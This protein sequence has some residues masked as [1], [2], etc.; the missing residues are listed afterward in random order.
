M[1]IPEGNRCFEDPLIEHGIHIPPHTLVVVVVGRLFVVRWR[2]RSEVH[3]PLRADACYACLDGGLS[4]RLGDTCTH[5]VSEFVQSGDSTV[6]K[7]VEGRA[8]RGNGVG[9]CAMPAETAGAFGR[10]LPE[11]VHDV[12]S[13]HQSTKRPAVADRISDD[14]QVRSD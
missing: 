5:A 12:R 10:H 11:L 8:P 7:D 6:L 14:G 2:F 13:P 4:Y 3:L 9:L 1:P